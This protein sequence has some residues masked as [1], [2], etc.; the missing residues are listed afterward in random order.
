MVIWI[1]HS[2]LHLK[3]PRWRLEVRG[4]WRPNWAVLAWTFWN[5]HWH[6]LVGNNV[7]RHIWLHLCIL[8]DVWGIFFI[9]EFALKFLFFKNLKLLF[10][11]ILRPLVICNYRLWWLFHIGT[12]VAEVSPA[13]NLLI[14]IIFL[15]IHIISVIFA[16][17]WFLLIIFR[18]K[19]E[20][21]IFLI[22]LR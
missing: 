9:L 18:S 14:C 20:V 4:T 11:N 1:T 8:H 17:L 13:G 16:S 12:K 10:L 15:I 5:L 22:F 2:A 3:K 21:F 19:C 6:L 7:L